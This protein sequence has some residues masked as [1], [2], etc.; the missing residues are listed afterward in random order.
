MGDFDFYA[1]FR[2][3]PPQPGGTLHQGPNLMV[4]VI[5]DLLT[6]RYSGASDR[7]RVSYHG[8]LGTVEM[9]ER[10]GSKVMA[11]NFN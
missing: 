4:K 8:E 2:L 7:L 6:M 5:M 1:I 10:L 3:Y 11:G 9:V